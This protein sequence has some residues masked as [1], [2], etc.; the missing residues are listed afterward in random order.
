MLKK[1][2]LNLNLLLVFLVL[3]K[4]SCVFNVIFA[5]LLKILEHFSNN[6]TIFFYA[7]VFD[8]TIK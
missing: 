2:T 5:L 7:T 1:I 8:F 6:K 3:I 4:L